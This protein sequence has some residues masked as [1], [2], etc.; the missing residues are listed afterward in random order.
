[1]AF[2]SS[3]FGTSFAVTIMISTLSLLIG[4]VY[5]FGIPKDDNFAMIMESSSANAS[6]SIPI[7]QNT[8]K[9]ETQYEQ[10]DNPEPV[11]SM[12]VPKASHHK[13][14][15]N[16]KVLEIGMGCSGTS[17]MHKFFEANH[18]KAKHFVAEHQPL[19]NYIFSNYQNGMNL[20]WG[21]P[22]D[23]QYIGD[24]KLAEGHVRSGGRSFSKQETL[25]MVKA[26]QKQ[27]ANATFIILTRPLPHWV[28]CV[29]YS[30]PNQ[31]STKRQHAD[32]KS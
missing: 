2:N 6:L 4:C 29:V 1:M 3:T 19:H 24:L 14:P 11:G 30:F 18:F 17:S 7:P 8:T 21:M 27:N 31:N 20:L 9:N 16:M 5:Y 32:R 28:K 15:S 23:L 13:P 26:L 10:W 12:E 22:S 25:G